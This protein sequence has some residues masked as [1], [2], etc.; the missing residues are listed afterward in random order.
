MTF[1]GWFMVATGCIGVGF[2]A[3]GIHD[4]IERLS[5]GSLRL[6]TAARSSDVES[7][8]AL[9]GGSERVEEAGEGADAI[10]NRRLEVVAARGTES[11]RGFNLA[12]RI[13]DHDGAARGTLDGQTA[14]IAQGNGNLVNQG[15]HWINHT[16]CPVS[17]WRGRAIAIAAAVTIGT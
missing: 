9:F 4:T 7:E 16:D 5:S 12:L 17:A 3:A 11:N 2:L 1:T 10:L 13:H 15:A 14:Q 8:P 6:R